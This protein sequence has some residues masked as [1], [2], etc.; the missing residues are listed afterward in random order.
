MKKLFNITCILV[1][2]VSGSFSQ[3]VVKMEMPSQSDQVINVVK[4]YDESLPLNTTIVLGAIGYNITG[5][6]APYTLN[7]MK[8]DKVVTTGDIAVI[9]PETGS[10]YS[11]K[12]IDKNSCSYITSI[13]LDAV[14]KMKKQNNINSQISVTPTLVTNQLTVSFNDNITTAASVRIF[15][16]QGILKYQQ[17]ISGNTL[18]PINLQKGVYYIVVEREELN[19]AE[20][21][22]VK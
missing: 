14:L 21:V 10:S 17:N 13:N 6:T 1:L 16:N 19:L 22:I 15:D 2:F 5:G 18:I 8:D 20:K 11:L 7:W 4:L 12:V 3:T 9:N